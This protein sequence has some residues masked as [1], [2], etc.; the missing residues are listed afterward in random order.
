MHIQF[1]ICTDNENV[2]KMFD[3]VSNV[4]KLEKQSYTKLYDDR[5]SW[6]LNCLRDDD[7][8]KDALIDLCILS[9]CN[10]E[11]NNYHTIPDSTFLDV[12]R[13]ISGWERCV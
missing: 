8:V 4:I 3:N 10:T 11:N 6:R 12:S 1:F 2:D 5:K 9:M 7:S 13:K